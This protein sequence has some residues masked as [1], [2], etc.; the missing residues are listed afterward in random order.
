[1]VKA[2]RNVFS[3]DEPSAVLPVRVTLVNENIWLLI[4]LTVVAVVYI[5]IR[6]YMTSR[7]LKKENRSDEELLSTL[8]MVRRCSAADVFRSAGEEWNFS[9]HKVRQD[10]QRYLKT[11]EIPRYVGAYARKNV[12]EADLKYRDMVYPRSGGRP[13]DSGVV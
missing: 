10:F 13:P 4:G 8:A 7:S 9:E 1:M 11:G 2:G 6:N 12:T 5:G 3:V